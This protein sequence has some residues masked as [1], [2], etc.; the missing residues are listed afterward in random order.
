MYLGICCTAMRP[1]RIFRVTE[2][3][4]LCCVVAELNNC[5]VPSCDSTST[6]MTFCP[7][8]EEYSQ[9]WR[10]K[11]D[12]AIQN[13]NFPVN[14]PEFKKY[15]ACPIFILSYRKKRLSSFNY[16]GTIYKKIAVIC[17][18]YKKK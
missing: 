7:F 10:S 2:T 8:S 6:T 13:T 5:R 9:E 12:G 18:K 1:F 3:L 16:V 4:L 17:K 11:C 14:C 15:H